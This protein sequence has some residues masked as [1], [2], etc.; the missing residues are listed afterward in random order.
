M[1][2]DNL[3]R[4]IQL[5]P[6]P[7]DVTIINNTIVGNGKAGILFANETANSTA[8][9][10]IVAY[11]GEYGI[12]GLS[13]DGDDNAARNNLVWGNP[14]GNFAFT[15]GISLGQNIQQAPFGLNDSPTRLRPP[16]RR[17]LRPRARRSTAARAPWLL[18]ASAVG[19]AA[20][21]RDQRCGRYQVAGKIHPVKILRGNVACKSARRN[22]EHFFRASDRRFR[23]WTCFYGHGGDNRSGH[24]LQGARATSRQGH[25]RLQ[26]LTLKTGAWASRAP[27]RSPR[28]PTKPLR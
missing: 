3:A 21:D 27:P 24:C 20:P 2:V 19:R 10:N 22:L 26:P 4:G 9:N 1:I 28:A 7:H 11:N 23:G 5:Y 12:R 6:G 8:S 15:A 14:R 18:A 25:P 16:A 17:C 13:L